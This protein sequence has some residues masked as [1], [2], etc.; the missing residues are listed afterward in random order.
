VLSGFNG[1]ETKMAN[2]YK[3]LHVDIMH[4]SDIG[5]FKTLVDILCIL[6]GPSTIEFESLHLMDKFVL[7]IKNTFRYQSFKIPRT[8]K[9]G[10]CSNANFAAFEHQSDVGMRLIGLL[11]GRSLMIFRYF[12]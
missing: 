1:G 3:C 8:N 9:G 12:N 2:P 7:C 5:V 6:A 11:C 10:F 4:Q